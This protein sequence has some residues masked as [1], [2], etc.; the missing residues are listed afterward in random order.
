M[1]AKRGWLRLVAMACGM[2]LFL[3]AGIG[4]AAGPIKWKMQTLWQ[5]GTISQKVDQQFADEV[6]AMSGGRLQIDV[7]PVGAV[8]GYKETLEA[9]GSGILD[10]H[11]SG[12]GYFSG[13]EP[14]FALLSDLNGL[15]ASPYDME[16]WFEYG[17]GKKLAR[18]LYAKY[19]VFYVGPVFW[20][21][22]SLSTKKAVRTIAGFKGMKLRVPEGTGQ[23]IFKYIGAAPVGL[24]GSEVYTSLDRGV[25]DGAD[26][27]VIAMNEDLGFD[28]VAK[29]SYYPGF[30]SMPMSEVAVNMDKWK[31][32]PD[33]LKAIVETATRDLSHNMVES[34]A[35]A[36]ADAVKTA[37]A[38][39][40]T[41]IDLSPAQRAIWRRDVRHVLDKYSKRSKLAR[42]IYESQISF[43]KRLGQIH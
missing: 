2:G 16:E 26:W 21:V 38:H 39:G 3:C 11:Q 41:L 31:A 40:V 10:A 28:K 36:N 8:V 43:L 29:Y 20:G 42:E 23:E 37:K 19:N 12:A 13:K 1:N 35:V 32:L 22:E 25:I 4:L 7:L 6:K 24:P 5:A 33:D 18:K 14:A 17:G 30:H 15:Y 9:M 27:S 34:M